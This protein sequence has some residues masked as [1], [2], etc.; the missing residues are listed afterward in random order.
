[1]LGFTMLDFY[2]LLTALVVG[3]SAISLVLFIKMY[4]S[5]SRPSGHDDDHYEDEDLTV[6][7]INHAS[8]IQESDFK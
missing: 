2:T 1:M 8:I 7:L 5:H 6:T 4:G 3:I